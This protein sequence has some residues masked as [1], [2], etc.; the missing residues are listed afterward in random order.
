MYTDEM[1]TTNPCDAFYAAPSPS[2]AVALAIADHKAA[3]KHPMWEYVTELQK[4]QDRTEAYPRLVAA[5]RRYVG[6][7][8]SPESAIREQA[9]ALLHDLG[10]AE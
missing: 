9:H 4:A 2:G 7:A 1:T 3:N 6:D 8:F 10:E 5:L